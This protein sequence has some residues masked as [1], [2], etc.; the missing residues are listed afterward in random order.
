MRKNTGRLG[1]KRVNYDFVDLGD[2]VEHVARLTLAREKKKNALS[3]KMRDELEDAFRRLVENE[4]VHVV[5]LAGSAGVFC[6][7]YDLKEGMESGGSAFLYRFR[8]FFEACYLFPKPVV[9]AVDGP[10]LAGGFDLALM[11]DFI[12]ASPRAV[13]GHPEIDFG[14]VA[15]L[16]LARFVAPARLRELCMLGEQIDAETA[17]NYGIVHEIVE[18]GRTETAADTLAALLAAKPP[19]ALA[20][21]KR[22]LARGVRESINADA[23]ALDAAL[24]ATGRAYDDYV[25]KRIG[26]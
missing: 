19:A 6:A 17:K 11:A 25:S 14:P 10:A 5:V 24:T 4:D 7:G 8:E 23:E 2:P 15:I 20:G 9:A 21:S 26:S 3:M 16:P 13:F 22:A 12:I 1:E 18:P